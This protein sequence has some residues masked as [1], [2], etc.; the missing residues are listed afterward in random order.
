MV[1]I[2]KSGHRLLLVDRFWGHV[3]IVN[4][5]DSCWLWLGHIRPS[6]YGSQGNH[7]AHRLSWEIHF[8]TIPKG[9]WV[10]H[11]CD[12]PPCVRPNH[13]FLG[14][15]LDN[16]RDRG[17][18]GRNGHGHGFKTE[19]ILRGEMHPNSRLTEEIVRQ[20]RAQYQPGD[21]Y[22][23]LGREFGIGPGHTRQIILR[24]SWA[25]VD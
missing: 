4:D 21:S 8:G 10:L 19:D 6:G 7:R 3:G 22:S 20:M 23:A 18:K 25:H 11:T 24:E 15:P 16:A 12:N 14:T 1:K 9:I 5:D 2:T 17:A 13:L